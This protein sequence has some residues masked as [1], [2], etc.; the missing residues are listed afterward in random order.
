MA[1][2][3]ENMRDVIDVKLQGARGKLT[4]TQSIEGDRDTFISMLSEQVSKPDGLTNLK[5]AQGASAK[6]RNQADF[7]ANSLVGLL[8]S[9]EVKIE[10]LKRKDVNKWPSIFEGFDVYRELFKGDD[11]L[12]YYFVSAEEA[13]V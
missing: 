12:F 1:Q 3:I 4:D 5:I 10:E 9:N 8:L 2:T 11:Y 6:I 13:R 7:A